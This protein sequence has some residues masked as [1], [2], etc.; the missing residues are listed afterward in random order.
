M[1]RQSSFQHVDSEA[2]VSI[3]TS[4]SLGDVERPDRHEIRF[5]GEGPTVADLAVRPLDLAPSLYESHEGS[6]GISSQTGHGRFPL[7]EGQADSSAVTSTG[8]GL[9][10]SDVRSHAEPGISG[11]SQEIGAYSVPTSYLYL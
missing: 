3:A 10:E 5:R 7:S 2:S 11:K 8:T 4:G 1:S 9:N 6:C